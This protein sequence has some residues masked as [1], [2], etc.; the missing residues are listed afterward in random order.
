MID[1]LSKFTGKNNNQNMEKEELNNLR[2]EVSR[3]KKKYDKLDEEILSASED[4]VKNQIKII[5]IFNFAGNRRL[6]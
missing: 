5:F 4:D 6:R 1:F 2:K 3:L